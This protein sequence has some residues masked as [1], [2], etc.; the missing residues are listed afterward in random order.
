MQYAVIFLAG[1]SFLFSAISSD[2]V[3]E[4][5]PHLEDELAYLYQARIFANGEITAPMP[6]YYYAYWQPFIITNHDD[7]VRFGKYHPGWPA[8]LAVGVLLGQA[9]VINAF[10][11]ALTVALTY[12]LGREIFNEDVGLMGALLVTFSP[13]ALL[14][15]GTLMS[16]TSALFFTTTF[17]YGYWRITQSKHQIRWAVLSGVALGLVFTIRPTTAV[18]VAL[19]FVLHTVIMLI[20]RLDSPRTWFKHAKPSIV[21]ALMTL[22][23]VPSM[24]LFNYATWGDPTQNLYLLVWEYDT[25]GF[26][27]GYGV[28]GHSIAKGVRNMVFDLS[29]F[30]ADVFG[31]TA[32]PITENGQLLPEVQTHLLYHQ[33]TYPVAQG[34][35]FIVI[36]IGMLIGWR[37]H[38]LYAICFILATVWIGYPIMTK[39]D[40]LT[41]RTISEI[42]TP[43]W[44]WL[45]GGIGLFS[46]PLLSLRT[47]STTH[48]NQAL[49]IW[50][51]AMV[52]ISLIGIHLA[53][54]VGSQ[55]YSTRYLF[56]ALTAFSLLGAL[57]LA[58]LAGRFP[59][60][61][62][63]GALIVALVWGL[64][65]YSI[66]R[67]SVLHQFNRVS[68]SAIDQVLSQRQD[69]RPILVIAT[70]DN[71]VW[72]SFGSF[73]A[74][75][76]P[77]FRSDIIVAWDRFDERDELI[78][79]HPN[80]QV[81]DIEFDGEEA[82]L[83]GCTPHDAP[84]CR[85][86]PPA[87]N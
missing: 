57:G 58:W 21:L 37:R 29:M 8:L 36:G 12:R 14:L 17:I 66:P 63:Y 11:S 73:S 13:M 54:W 49:W 67:I 85:V 86:N 75:T 87:K 2:R 72:R 9:W 18:A 41:V 77:Y 42:Y 80:R 6:D 44:L 56:E 59:R 78:A 43:I 82:W 79:Q 1:L 84:E 60:R 26:G 39:A 40:F 16:H 70:G 47:H 3:F 65:T 61:W 45:L 19:P 10:V 81:I 64:V 50:L 76:D 62:I 69:E 31:W 28:A 20:L 48:Q 7:G 52:G 33:H 25:L 15:N 55:R 34:L 35:G 30:T 32:R 74:L 51:L 83:A 38:P 46:I 71:V 23:F 5:L 24:P 27:E 22:L 68:Q 53:Y 4:R